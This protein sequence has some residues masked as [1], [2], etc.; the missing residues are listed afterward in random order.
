M[1]NVEPKNIRNISIVGH[2]GTGKTTLVESIL[3][4]CGEISR[5]GS[6][7]KGTTTT[8]FEPEE[9]KR[10]ISI[11][12]SIAPCNWR[13]YKINIL[14]TPGYFDFIGEV[15]RSLKVSDGVV[16]LCDSIAGVEVGTEK[17]WDYCKN[18]KIPLII[19]INKMDRESADYYK[20]IE[21]LKDIYGTQIAPLIYQ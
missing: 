19:V 5:K 16:L 18:L 13:D 1:K 2:G 15:L 8:D 20:V 17:I 9:I 21:Q 7:E 12:T 11:S 3:F 14:D 10:N 4:N 6:T